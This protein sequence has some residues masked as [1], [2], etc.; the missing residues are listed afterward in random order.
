MHACFFYPLFSLLFYPL[1]PLFSKLSQEEIPTK[2]AAATCI[3]E[4]IVLGPKLILA[5]KYVQ[6]FNLLYQN[7]ALYIQV[8]IDTTGVTKLT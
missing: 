5:V 6:F 1:Y 4:K 3:Y 8:S 2:T 7:N